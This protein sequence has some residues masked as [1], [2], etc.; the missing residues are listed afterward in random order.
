MMQTPLS[1]WQ[2]QFFS[3]RV[4]TPSSGADGV[5]FREQVFG[6]LDVLSDALPDMQ[7]ALGEQNFRFFVRELLQKVQPKDALGTSLVEPFLCF[8]LSSPQLS[9]RPSELALVRATLERVRA[10]SASA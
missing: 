6:A 1:K 9:E 10:N 7:S 3:K 2:A 4:R 5:Y 8:V